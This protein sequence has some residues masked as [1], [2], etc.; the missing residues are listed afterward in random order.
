MNRVQISSKNVFCKI[1]SDYDQIYNLIEKL[2]PAE[3]FIFGKRGVGENYL[4]WDF[5]EG[6]WR[7]IDKL[8]V[9]ERQFVLDRIIKIKEKCTPILSEA[10]FSNSLID[11]VFS[12]PD[13]KYVFVKGR[14]DA[15]YDIMLGA[16]GYKYPERITADGPVIRNSETLKYQNANLLFLNDQQPVP[17]RQFNL[18]FP[19]GKKKMLVCDKAGRYMVSAIPEGY[20]LVV[21]DVKTQ[22]RFCHKIDLSRQEYICDL[23]CYCNIEVHVHEADEPLAEYP[24]QIE[25]NGLISTLTTD[26]SGKCS[27]R[28]VIADGFLCKVT[29]GKKNEERILS[30]GLEVFDFLLE[31]VVQDIPMQ[32]SPVIQE[33]SVPEVQDDCKPEIS[34]EREDE[35]PAESADREFYPQI[36]IVGTDGFIGAYY[37]ITVTLD[38]K[39]E[40]RISDRD[41]II[42]IGIQKEGG[43]MYVVDSYNP[44]N[45]AVYLLNAEQQE[46]I[47]KVPYS[48][49]KGNPDIKIIVL[50]KNDKPLDAGTILF[51]QDSSDILANLNNDG[52]VYLDKNYFATD[53]PISIIPT[54]A[55]RK[56]KPV[57]FQIKKDETE[58]IVHIE[59][60]GLWW[61][62]VLEILM[63][64]FLIIL[65]F[66][67]YYL[68]MDLITD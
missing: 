6:E 46:Y 58:Y 25:Y 18:V 1:K 8:D 27:K 4:Q 11:S 45:S 68:L 48:S 65:F 9:L 15:Q 28:L 24:V 31:P 56:F 49:S 23:T 44:Q 39:T 19:S 63:I 40:D 29:A 66:F 5:P 37:P 3:C 13:D 41:G 53:K 54:V 42:K 43:K 35:I 17:D 55:D 34:D 30:K 57:S 32:D 7:S 16:W 14:Q 50:D 20:E 62:R 61:K 12:V 33:E 67:S 10:N 21:E 38:D 59:K 22:K 26:T 36:K 51:R 52:T 47:F 60:P 64:V 2:V